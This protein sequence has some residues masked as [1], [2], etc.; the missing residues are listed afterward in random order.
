MYELFYRTL[1]EVGLLVAAQFCGAFYQRIL[2]S[3]V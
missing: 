1:A 3:K 2:F